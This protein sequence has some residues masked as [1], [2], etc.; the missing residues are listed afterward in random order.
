[1]SSFKIFDIAGSAMTAQSL[2]LN[3]VAS[4]LSNA[5]SVSSSINSTYK[6]RHPVFATQ[7]QEA[8]SRP[9]HVWEQETAVGVDVLG[10]VESQAPTL[11][12][13]APEHPLADEKGYIFRP[14]VNPVE[15]MTNMIAASR[16][17]QDS[18]EVADTAKQLMLQ[19][20]RLGQ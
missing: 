17:Y 19:T 13:Y 7:L 9:G 2:R 8:M 11:M 14:N 20:L 6:A 15:E 12:E 16:A 4:N 5:E 18:A 3:L 10:V 1:M